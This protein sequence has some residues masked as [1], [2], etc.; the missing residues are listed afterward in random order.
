[1]D[2]PPSEETVSR[3]TSPAGTSRLRVLF[4]G[5][6]LLVLLGS[7]LFWL[8]TRNEESTDDAFIEAN[9]VQISARVS[10]YVTQVAV[11][12]NQWVKPGDLLAL[13]DPRDFELRVQ[14][15][16]ATLNA[17]KARHGAATQDLSVVT[18][19]SH[20]EIGQAEAQLKAAEARA[21]LAGT[22]LSRYQALFARDEVSRQ[23]LDQAMLDKK[24][25]DADLTRAKERLAG[26][27]SGPRQIDL[28][29]EQ[30]ASGR[31]SVEEAQAALDQARLDLSYTRLTSPVA[32]HVAKKNLDLGQLVQPGA[33]IMA[34]V[35]GPPWVVANFK[36][37]QL[38]RMKPGQKVTIQVDAFPNRK[39]KGHVDSLQPGTGARFSLLP[40][41][42]ATGNYV[43]VVQRIPVKIVFDENPESLMALSPGMSVEPTVELDDP[44]S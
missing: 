12:D 23:R 19:T 9:V 32:G 2:A 17:A 33:S 5:L 26:A 25:A 15:A 14:Q 24:T 7:V 18:T 10:G 8:M 38:R 11:N 36:E 21:D 42:N 35:Y 27:L 44:R 4:G 34:I 13:V 31:A 1:M 29:K 16:E 3:P 20:A 39:F 22:D 28:K 41:E 6:V 43:K 37:T 30:A 40:P